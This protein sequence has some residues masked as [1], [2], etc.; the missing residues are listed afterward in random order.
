MPSPR[1]FTFLLQLFPLVQSHSHDRDSIPHCRIWSGT[2]KEE[3]SQDDE[4]VR[5]LLMAVSLRLVRSPLHRFGFMSW[6]CEAEKRK[7]FSQECVFWYSYEI[8]CAGTFLYAAS[9]L[10]SRIHTNAFTCLLILLLFFL[11]KS[12]SKH[13]NTCHMTSMPFTCMRVTY[14][15]RR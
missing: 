15:D 10:I 3:D 5:I 9:C 13:T 4:E 7:G 8:M 2:L 14:D 1:M 12:H 6:I 11:L